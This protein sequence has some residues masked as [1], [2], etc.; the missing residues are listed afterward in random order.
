MNRL[1]ALLLVAVT[2]TGLV[3][4]CASSTASRARR[5]NARTIS[6]SEYR[7]AARQLAVDIVSSPKFQRFRDSE[8]ARNGEIVVMLDRYD[9]ST[10][11]DPTFATNVRQLFTALE[12]QLLENDLTFQQDLDPGSP[13]Y[14]RA[15]ERLDR[16]DADDRYDQ[17]TGDISTGSAKKAVLSLQLEVQGSRTATS[18]GGSQ[19]EYVLIARVSNAQKVSFLS[20]SYELSKSNR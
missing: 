17:S 4:G 14:S 9:T 7:Q 15:G 1:A 3:A 20:K 12:E 16:Q 11:D 19:Y 6:L 5:D 18:G 8:V 13:N 2:T 10:V